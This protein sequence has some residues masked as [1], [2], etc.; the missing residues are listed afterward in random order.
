MVNIYSEK[1]EGRKILIETSGRQ[2]IVRVAVSEL[3]KRTATSPETLEYYP[4]NDARE[5]TAVAIVELFPCL[6]LYNRGVQPHSHFYNTVSQTGYIQTR[7]NTCVKLSAL[8]THLTASQKKRQRRSTD[9]NQPCKR[10]KVN[11]KQ[12]DTPTEKEL[13]VHANEASFIS[14]IK[15]F[16]KC[17]VIHDVF[18]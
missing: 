5:Q 10:S 18:R 13:Q 9:E 7:L 8:R 16:R 3:I 15:Y 1:D 12:E 17:L 11:K 14:F 6:G 4:G 2:I